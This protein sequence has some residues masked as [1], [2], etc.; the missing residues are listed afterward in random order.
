MNPKK[1]KKDVRDVKF[2]TRISQT[3]RE[4]LTALAK[5]HGV[6]ATEL[7]C[8]LMDRELATLKKGAAQDVR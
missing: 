4:L 7:I 5:H 2:C 8:R 1:D 3:E 6:S